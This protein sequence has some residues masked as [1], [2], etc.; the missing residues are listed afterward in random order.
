MNVRFF[1]VV[2]FGVTATL[3]C[4]EV[5][6][7]P[8][9][10]A[11]RVVSFTADKTQ[12]A[13]GEVVTLHFVTEH[14]SEVQLLDDQ[15]RFIELD[16]A[17]AQGTATVAPARTSFYVLRAN[18]AGGSDAAFV[19]LAVDEAAR[20]VFLLA[21][22]E[23]LEAGQSAQLLWGA[24]G[25]AQVTLQTG[26]E[27][28]VL[29]TGGTGTVTVTPARSQR[30]TLTAGPARTALTEVRVKPKLSSLGLEAPLGLEPGAMLSVRWSSRGAERVVVRELTFGQLLD[31]GDEAQLDEG[32]T[33]WT[34]PA[35]LP[36]GVPVQTGVP[37]RFEVTV[38]SSGGV[39]VK[40]VS[41]VVGDAPVIE[42]VTAPATASLGLDFTLAWNTLN[43][44]T[45]R[46]EA[47]DRVVFETL[48]TERPRA[49]AGS[50][51]LPSPPVQ[52]TYSVVATNDRGVT[53]RQSVNV[54][55]VVVPAIT[56]FTLSPPTINAPGETVIA[57]WSAMNARRIQ[58]RAVNGPTIAVN[59][60]MPNNGSI[61]FRAGGAQTLQ[62]EAINE[63]GDLVTA[64]AT[65]GLVNAPVVSIA[66]TPTL[67]GITATLSWSLA[68]LGV[69]EVVGLATPRPAKVTGSGD[70]VDLTQRAALEL[71]FADRGD[72]AAELPLP[73]GFHF[74]LLGV[75]RPKL[76]VSVNGFVSFA[77]T[78]ALGTNLALTNANAPSLLAPY[79]DDLSL[80]PT[81]RVL[82]GF[83][84]PLPTGERRYVIQWDRVI[85]GGVEVT[86]Q[87]QLT[88]TGT[89]RFVYGAMNGKNGDTATIGVSD[90]A[91]EVA[92]Q[93]SFNAPSVTDDDELGFFAG[94]PA[95]GSFQFVALGT[96]AVTFTG[97]T[98]SGV[99]PFVVPLVA[100]SPGD[101]KVSEAMPWP[102]P[103]VSFDGQW[104]ELRNVTDV[105]ID[106]ASVTLRSAGSTPDGGHVF[107]H[108]VIP[109]RGY[110]VAG[111]ST[112][113][114]ENGGAGVSVLMNDVPLSPGADTLTLSLL[115]T[116]LD[117]L[118]WP[119]STEGRSVQ[120]VEG[121]LFG[122]GPGVTPLCTSGTRTFGP[123][124]AFGTPGQPNE[125]CAPYSIQRIT[126]AYT[127][128]GSAAGDVELLATASDYSG[129]GDVT[130]PAPFT[131][132]GQPY[133]SM[134]VS[135]TGFVTFGHALTR[136]FDATNDTLPEATAPNG[137]VAIF[138][139]Q[140]VRNTGGHIW[141]RRGAGRTIVSWQDFRIY[142]TTGSQVNF[143]LH[144]LDTGVIEFHYG[145]FTAPT[146]AAELRVR[147]SSATV[148]LEPPEGGSAVSVGVNTEGTITQSS[149]IR[150]TP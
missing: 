106:L 88:E 11:A 32:S 51:R 13:A 121:V 83:G 127:P 3:G 81:S 135:M 78:A 39:D 111:T 114:T 55:P 141:L 29:L 69:D 67:A 104:V 77:P 80:A 128:L 108:T 131:Y 42:R 90:V 142:A 21:V 118:S 62:L 8:P 72:G 116:T 70:F 30:Y 9:P 33:T 125:P 18:G 63:A 91:Q 26:D 96:K 119:T 36:T 150:F 101:L 4:T 59:E 99:I 113:P 95:D 53:A 148:W 61:T 65:L 109:P 49:Q 133:G 147:G 136:A 97:R 50:V 64:T 40:T 122:S 2:W 1:A 16:G 15:G 129:F 87:V 24:P 6:A 45:V 37:L 132:F 126:G 60:T 58:L 14:A 98:S 44:A 84:P 134:S 28:P 68:A 105:A 112:N 117:S 76:W 34:V 74:M 73:P 92:Q 23:A 25:A 46:V 5:K 123:H 19:Q 41:G 124:G 12:L 85:A 82:A 149:G 27:P 7:P 43:A 139:D 79:W 89:V 17:P 93:V 86:F 20:E 145:P 66:P 100:L 102:A 137:V 75:E 143:Q 140:I 31:T 52:T 57:Q 94:Q 115:G 103:A 138:W 130:L 48:P 10:D 47:D 56:S 144:L 71:I 110:V 35:T 146:A 22:P 38:S 54:R 120:V 107:G